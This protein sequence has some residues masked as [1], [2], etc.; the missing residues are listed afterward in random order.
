MHTKISVG[1][2]DGMKP[3]DRIVSVGDR[4]IPEEI[5]N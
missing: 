3:P 5:I 2:P 4:T 1:K